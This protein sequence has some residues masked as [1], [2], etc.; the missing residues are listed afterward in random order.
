EP[1]GRGRQVQMGGGDLDRQSP[2]GRVPLPVVDAVGQLQPGLGDGLEPGDPA[3]PV[4]LRLRLRLRHSARDGGAGTGSRAIRRRLLPLPLDWWP[5]TKI[6]PTS[7]VEATWVPPSAWRSRPSMSTT[8]IT[9]S[10]WGTRLV[11]VRMSVGRA[12]DT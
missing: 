9:S 7:P 3:Q 10:P 1:L 6:V 5:T 4:R 11:L 8:R 12:G 2:Q